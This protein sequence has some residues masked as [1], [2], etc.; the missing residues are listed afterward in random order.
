M[1]LPC[2]HQRWLRPVDSLQP[3]HITMGESPAGFFCQ[4]KNVSRQSTL[5]SSDFRRFPSFPHN[6]LIYL[7]INSTTILHGIQA[8]NSFFLNINFQQRFFCRLFY[9]ILKTSYYSLD[10][11]KNPWHNNRQM[12]GPETSKSSG[13]PQ[14][15]AVW[16][17]ARDDADR[18]H[19]ES[20]PLNRKETSLSIGALN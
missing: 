11:K 14:R 10:T 20:S 13:V 1:A 17:E 15:A 8:E 12:P 18:I 4:H 16:W 5:S 19:S 3:I 9:D 2:P 6:I 7:L